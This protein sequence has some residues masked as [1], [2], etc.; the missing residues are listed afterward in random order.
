M[1]GQA[2]R[3]LELKGGQIYKVPF[4]E[5]WRTGSYGAHPTSECTPMK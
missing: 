5:G 1:F 2:N 4:H 3:E